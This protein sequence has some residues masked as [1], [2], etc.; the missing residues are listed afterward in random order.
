ME[1]RREGGSQK[2]NIRQVDGGD[3]PGGQAKQG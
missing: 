3:L 2:T 1:E